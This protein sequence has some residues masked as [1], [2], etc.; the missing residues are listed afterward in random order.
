MLLSLRGMLDLLQAFYQNDI[1]MA[2]D[3]KGLRELLYICLFCSCSQICVKICLRDDLKSNQIQRFQ[4]SIGFGDI[5]DPC[6]Q[7]QTHLFCNCNIYV[8]RFALLLWSLEKTNQEA[9]IHF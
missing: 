5:L 4:F 7:Q 6:Q 2:T 8:C 1:Y 3:H 9:G